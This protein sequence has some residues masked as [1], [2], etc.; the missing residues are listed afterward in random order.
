VKILEKPD[1]IETE[2]IE[3]E[4]RNPDREQ[5]NEETCREGRIP[6]ERRESFPRRL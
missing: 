1:G 3:R 2:K 6:R 5:G 4:Q